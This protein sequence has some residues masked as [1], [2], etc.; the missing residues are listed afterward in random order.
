MTSGKKPVGLTDS[1]GW[2]TGIRRTL[3]INPADAWE[4]LF[5]QPVLGYW[6]DGSASLPF[7]KNDTYTTAS[8]ITIR[9][10][11]V[12]TGKV[13]RMKWQE[14]PGTDSSTLQI[15]VIPAKEKTVI[16]FH[17]EW[18]KD[19]KERIKMNDYWKGVLDKIETYLQK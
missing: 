4:M 2:E 1:Q 16:A 13:I 12:T 15:R 9:V 3:A 11:S 5:T 14:A 17:H 19:E 18:L 6:L 10:A 8:G 7:E